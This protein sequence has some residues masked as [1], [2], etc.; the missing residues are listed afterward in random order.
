M[1]SFV[2]G[3]EA[4][5]PGV[6]YLV[7]AGPGDPNLLTCRALRL[8]QTAS[9][10]IHDALITV[11]VLGLASQAMLINV[12]KRSGHHLARQG[13]IAEIMISFAHGNHKVVRL[14]GGDPGVFGRVGEEMQA[15]RKADVAYEVVP[16]ISSVIAASG[17][18][19]ISLTH[20]MLSSAVT[21][22]TGHEAA[23]NSK[24]NH[25][26]CLKDLR[27]TLVIL[28]GLAKLPEITQ[29]LLELG[30]HPNT[31]VAVVQSASTSGQKTIR[32][33]LHNIA[34][35]SEISEIAS[36]ATVIIGKVA[37]LHDQLAWRREQEGPT[38]FEPGA[39]VSREPVPLISKG[40]S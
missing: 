32:G 19:G 39:R 30:H 12:G 7:G 15:L 22:I 37:A 40:D 31:P 2:P 8:L 24:Q 29:K 9:V 13:G 34:A 35:M 20:R 18:S 6:V 17:L 3:G 5:V 23:R 36:P 4:C 11:E 27:H 26:M 38:P 33:V 14:K 1:N 10:V 16:G 28:M 25:L 21:V